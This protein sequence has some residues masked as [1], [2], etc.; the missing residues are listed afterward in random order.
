M[1]ASAASLAV[2]G[3]ALG[4]LGFMAFA[5]QL[6]L[7]RSGTPT[8]RRLLIAVMASAAWELCGIAAFA[9]PSPASWLVHGLADALRYGAWLYFLAALLPAG[10]NGIGV[11]VRRGI[12]IVTTL[13]LVALTLGPMDRVTG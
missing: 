6:L 9:A 12:P 11:L 3:Y 4:A 8:A 7:R 5:A 2:A 13:I 10:G 1:N